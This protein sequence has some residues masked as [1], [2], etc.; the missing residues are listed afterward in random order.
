M[1]VA[2]PADRL[3]PP[4]QGQAAVVAEHVADARVPR[5][6]EVV[7]G[8]DRLRASVRRVE[9]REQLPLPDPPAHHPAG[10]GQAHVP[11]GDGA[12]LPAALLVEEAGEV[13]LPPVV[14]R[15]PLGGRRGVRDARQRDRDLPEASAGLEARPEPGRPGDVHAHVEQAALHPGGRPDIAQRLEHAAPAVAHRRQRR[16]DPGQQRRPGRARL[17]PRHVPSDHVAAGDRDEHDRVAVQV[18]AVEVHHVVR[19]PV[20]RHGRPQIPHQQVLAPQA[21]GRDAALLLALLGEQPVQTGAQ[22]R[23]PAVVRA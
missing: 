20:Q 10:L 1:L 21:P 22:V 4:R 17:A 11:V 13:P 9:E 23:G 3:D 6:D 8:R 16:R 12:V 14:R 19:G 15:H 18:D 5:L 2:P 7:R